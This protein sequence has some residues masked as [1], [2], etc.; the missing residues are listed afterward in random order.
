MMTSYLVGSFLEDENLEYEKSVIVSPLLDAERTLAYL[1]GLHSYWLTESTPLQEPE[2][3]AKEWLN[4]SF[5]TGGLQIL[6][7]PNPY[8]EEKGEA[9]S[10]TSTPGNSYFF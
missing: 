1:L 8:E 4:A 9:R 6:L 2:E 3:E 5:L 10:A 7:P